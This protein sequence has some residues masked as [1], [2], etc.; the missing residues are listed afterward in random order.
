MATLEEMVKGLEGVP[1]DDPRRQKLWG[2]LE[3]KPD[4][5]SAIPEE[6]ADWKARILGTPRFPLAGRAVVGAIR[7]GVSSLGTP[8]DIVNFAANLPSPYDV[9][10]SGAE[11]INQKIHGRGTVLPDL[12]ENRVPLP[13]VGGSQDF[14]TLVNR[15]S[16]R[17]GYTPPQT[18]AEKA[19]ENI[20]EQAVNFAAPGWLAR[21]LLNVAKVPS[22]VTTGNT[23]RDLLMGGGS[24]VGKTIA[25]QLAPGSPVAATTGML[26]GGVAP[27]MLEQMARRTLQHA[28]AR[29]LSPYEKNLQEV[30]K[31]EQIPLRASE[32]T[33][34]STARKIEEFPGYTITGS[35]P[36]QE[37]AQQTLIRGEEALGRALNPV[38]SP[39]QHPN[40]VGQAIRS[41]LE[42][43]VTQAEQAAQLAA[44]QQAS[45]ASGRLNTF[46]NTAGPA[47]DKLDVADVAKR[48][49]AK[50]KGFFDK[51][52]KQLFQATEQVT[53]D[54]PVVTL[55]NFRRQLDA[56]VHEAEQ[57]GFALPR[58]VGGVQGLTQEATAGGQLLTGALSPDEAARSLFR[59][60]FSLLEPT[61][62]AQVEKI[63]GQVETGKIPFWVAR[64][65]ESRFG[66][67]GFRCARPIGTIDEGKAKALYSAI[68]QDQHDFMAS[69]EVEQ[70][71]GGANLSTDLQQ[72][73]AYY[74]K[75][76]QL[77]N[78][79]VVSKL[80]DNDPRSVERFLDQTVKGPEG[81]ANLKY[82]MDNAGQETKEAFRAFVL[83]D[84]Y[85]KAHAFA[86]DPTTFSAKKFVNLVQPWIKS[87][88]LDLLLEPGSAVR[89]TF[90]QQLQDFRSL[91]EQAAP[92]IAPV[93]K[94]FLA[95]PADKILH[96]VFAPGQF[97]R[98]QEYRQIATPAQFDDAVRAWAANFQQEIQANLKVPRDAKSTVALP[99]RIVKDLKPLAESGQL[100][101]MFTQYPG[102]AG[103]LKKLLPLY[104]RLASVSEKTLTREFGGYPGGIAIFAQAA[105]IFYS[106]SK[107]LTGIYAQDPRLIARG[108]MEGGLYERGPALFAKAVR[109]PT[110]VRLLSE[111]LQKKYSPAA[112]GFA[113]RVLATDNPEEQP[114]A[115]L[116]IPKQERILEKKAPVAL[117]PLRAQP[118]QVPVTVNPSAMPPVAQTP[119][120]QRSVSVNPS[121]QQQ[122]RERLAVEM[123]RELR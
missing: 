81:I 1:A 57:T 26:L 92:T 75:H 113:L 62:K 56:F 76:Y 86:G 119:S 8:I 16:T 74:R 51:T 40:V 52:K 19:A 91:A 24:G 3:K 79:S 58:A 96:S 87:G 34:S 25:E 59:K 117:K 50:Q 9:A 7:G 20:P 118:P 13:M 47:L 77:F 18:F 44:E 99:S 14:A 54:M 97:V 103:Q 2:V 70:F 36:V 45:Q 41:D 67:I 4:F 106:L 95:Q 17:F 63:I 31:E 15:L 27:A 83:S 35:G 108:L 29:P 94:R 122:E 102:V 48:D 114:E 85:D 73:K 39:S 110:G 89:Q 21:R 88:K 32:I 71:L 37:H 115:R 109:T 93:E 82:V 64:R 42:G 33:G 101:L 104:E 49:F 28:G 72:A 112:V 69:P 12:S 46:R 66:E 23:L 116:A 5:Q 120:P 55:N 84:L 111:G 10:Q 78:E 98:T 61:E 107:V 11:W 68:K 60:P 90:D 80:F 123:L 6:Q 43:K 53:G 30:A 105:G 65:L 100:D 38:P 121:L 22:L